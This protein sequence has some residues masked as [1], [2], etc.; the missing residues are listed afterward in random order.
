MSPYG[1]TLSEQ[2][3]AARSRQES[4]TPKLHYLVAPFVDNGHVD[5]VHKDRHSLAG[6]RAVRVAHA[7]V[8]VALYRPLEAQRGGR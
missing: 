7:F 5:V 1:T 6:R 2:S 8:H 4:A 3:L